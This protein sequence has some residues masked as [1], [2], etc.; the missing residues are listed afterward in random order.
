MPTKEEKIDFKEFR[1]IIEKMKEDGEEKV[2]LK[3]NAVLDLI[4]RIIQLENRIKDL[5]QIETEH[6]KINADLMKKLN[7]EAMLKDL[8]RSKLYLDKEGDEKNR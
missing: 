6:K 7:M 1:R 8:K 3:I 4:N 2:V 5:E